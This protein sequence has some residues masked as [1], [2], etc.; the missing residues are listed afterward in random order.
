MRFLNLVTP[1]DAK[2]ILKLDGSVLVDVREPFEI[3]L[4]AVRDLSTIYIPLGNLESSTD[5][6]RGYST[7][8]LICRTD[9][10]SSLAAQILENQFKDKNI[11]IVKGGIVQ[12]WTDYPMEI[13]EGESASEWY[14]I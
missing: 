3:K 9:K 11:F 1:M 12:W 7:I 13:T 2:E 8:V 6:L 14:A 5:Q 4:M 10:R